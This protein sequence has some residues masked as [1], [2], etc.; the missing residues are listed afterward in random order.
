MPK[1]VLAA[2]NAV[3]HLFG[4]IALHLHFLKA[5]HAHGLLQGRHVRTECDM[6]SIG[7]LD[8]YDLADAALSLC[9]SLY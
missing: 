8:T 5:K 4:G 7:L 1:L 2:L 9:Q 3:Q 6:P